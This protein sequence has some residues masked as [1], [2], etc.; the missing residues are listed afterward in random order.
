MERPVP[1][2]KTADAVVPVGE[3][4][5]GSGSVRVV[6]AGF[7]E[8]RSEAVVAGGFGGRCLQIRGGFSVRR[9]SFREEPGGSGVLRA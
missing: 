1:G 3:S 2:A 8:G 6:E 4:V 9:P 7:R 5:S